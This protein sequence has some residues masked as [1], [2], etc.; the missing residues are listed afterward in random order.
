MKTKFDLRV[1]VFK[2]V[3]HVSLLIFLAPF[4]TSAKFSGSV[5]RFSFDFYCQTSFWELPTSG[6]LFL[7]QPTLKTKKFKST[8]Q[9]QTRGQKKALNEGSLK[10][11]PMPF[12]SARDKAAQ[13]NLTK[14]QLNGKMFDFDVIKLEKAKF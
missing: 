10:S 6:N 4:N 3:L 12:N 13:I 2:K 14:H 11:V 5:F 8:T 7:P 1:F 9:A